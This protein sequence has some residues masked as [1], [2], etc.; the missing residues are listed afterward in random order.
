MDSKSIFVALAVAVLFVGAATAAT[1]QTVEQKP[2]SDEV[3]ITAVSCLLGVCVLDNETGTPL[4]GIRVTV[5]TDVKHTGENGV[6]EFTVSKGALAIFV[7]GKKRGYD[8]VN[9]SSYC[10]GCGNPIWTEAWLDLLPV[11]IPPLAEVP[12]TT[13]IG[14]VLLLVGMIAVGRKRLR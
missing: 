4:E 2:C 11:P 7:D 14:K 9:I 12:T 3:R 13:F 5:G 8:S 10:Y 1:V 6:A